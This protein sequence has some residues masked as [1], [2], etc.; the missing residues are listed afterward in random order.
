M[1]VVPSTI[2]NWENYNAQY[3]SDQ[4]IEAEKVFCDLK[5]SLKEVKNAISNLQPTP[6]ACCPFEI[7]EVEDDLCHE[8]K[9]ND[10]EIYTGILTAVILIAVICFI[11]GF[12]GKLKPF[13]EGLFGG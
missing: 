12:S 3:H 7:S 9:I 8:G 10:D 4:R 1:G 13:F 5:E 2:S 6:E 11:V